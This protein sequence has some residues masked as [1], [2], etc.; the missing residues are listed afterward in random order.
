MKKRLLEDVKLSD[1]DKKRLEPVM[2][3]WLACHAYGVKMGET[4]AAYEELKRMLVYEA[5]HGK[6]YDIARRIFGR[7]QSVRYALLVKELVE[8]FE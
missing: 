7:M 8:Y 5:Q 2:R 4:W 6:R 3:N 1:A